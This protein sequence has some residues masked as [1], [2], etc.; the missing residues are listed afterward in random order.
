MRVAPLTL[1]TAQAHVREMY[2]S[3]RTL[4]PELKLTIPRWAYPC[5]KQIPCSCTVG[6]S[7]KIKIYPLLGTIRSD[8]EKE[9]GAVH[10]GQEVGPQGRDNSME[11]TAL[12]PELKG[13]GCWLRWEGGPLI[14]PKGLA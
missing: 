10:G 7:V 11:Q 6:V 14:A 3:L 12:G 8:K 4:Q 9:K 5:W 2:F 13:V 1:H